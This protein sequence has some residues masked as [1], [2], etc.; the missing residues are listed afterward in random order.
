[1]LLGTTNQGT[2]IEIEPSETPETFAEKI[3]ALEKRDYFDAYCMAQARMTIVGKNQGA[4][5]RD[6]EWWAYVVER[7]ESDFKLIDIS[8]CKRELGITTSLDMVHHGTQLLSK[9]LRI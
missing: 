7:V 1:M 2:K 9:F 3:R 5:N 8:G 6:Y 4:Q